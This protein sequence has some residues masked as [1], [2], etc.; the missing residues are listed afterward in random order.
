[1]DASWSLEPTRPARGTTEASPRPRYWF[2]FNFSYV[3]AG[4]S[5]WEAIGRFAWRGGLI[6]GLG[7]LLPYA[8]G[9]AGA[10]NT[11]RDWAPGTE[12]P[13]TPESALERRSRTL[14]VVW[15]FGSAI[16][17]SAGG[18][19]F[20]HYFHLVLPAL[21]VLAAPALVRAWKTRPRWRPVILALGVGPALVS[22][23]VNTV[24]RDAVVVATSP[25]PPY[26]R[27]ARELGRISRPSDR[28]FVWGNSPQ[29]YVLAQRPMGARF[30]FCNYMTGISPG[31]KTDTGE[32]DPEV[33]ALPAAWQMLFDDLD[34]RQPRWVVDA[35][36]G[37]WDGY[38]PYRIERYPRLDRY[39]V[40]HYR[41]RERVD[42]VVL[43]ERGGK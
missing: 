36:A 14:A 35:S 42:G 2:E 29:V 9:L 19:F 5:G 43:Y 12:R 32:A 20:G 21:S 15:L 28:V 18:R 37:G 7:A 10:W 30:S 38:G 40:E 13:T 23:A 6:I 26:E 3:A 11:I 16:A 25:E 4:L 24:A 34:R 8:F 22:L 17:M 27:L 33:N 39:I 31:T 41:A 1:M